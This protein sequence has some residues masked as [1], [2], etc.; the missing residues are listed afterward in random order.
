MDLGVYDMIIR[1]T[2]DDYPLRPASEIIFKAYVLDLIEVQSNQNQI[3]HIADDMLLIPFTL[4]KID[5]EP[6]DF[7]TRQD[8]F[9]INYSLM[10]SS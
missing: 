5:P 6:H 1:A 2:L 7:L 4:W 10:D 9:A 3:Y 8:E